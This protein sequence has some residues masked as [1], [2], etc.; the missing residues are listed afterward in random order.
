MTDETNAAVEGQDTA[1]EAAKPVAEKPTKALK[2]PRAAKDGA[3]TVAKDD[4]IHDGKGGYLTKGAKF[5]PVDDE[6]AAELIDK[7]FAK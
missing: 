2:A 3:L 1:V 5:D 4:T 7:G 6:A